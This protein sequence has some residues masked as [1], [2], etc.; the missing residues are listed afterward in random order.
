MAKIEL[1]VCKNGDDTFLVWRIEKPI[2]GCRGFAVYRRR[3]GK[4]EILPSYAGFANEDW[5][6]G[7]LKPSTVWPVQKF[8]WTD[9]TVMTGDEVSYRVVP[10]A[11]PDRNHLQPVEDQASDWSSPA[12]LDPWVTQQIGCYFNRGI[13]ATQW[14]QRM[15]GASLSVRQRA[16]KL[17]QVVED[18]KNPTARNALAGELRDGLLDLLKKARSQKLQV[19]AALFELTDDELIGALAALGEK[20]FVVL[21]DGAVS[22][23]K[24]S[25]N[26]VPAA[27]STTDEN[28]VARKT[29]EKAK[30]EVHSRMTK[31]KFLAHNK[32]LVVCDEKGNPHLTW[33]G[34]TN[35][36]PSGLC[37][38]ANN[39]LLIDDG[40]LATHFQ[41]Q[42]K[43]LALAGD[44]SPPS[45]ASVNSE[46]VRAKLGKRPVTVWFTRTNAEVDLDDAK[47]RIAAARDGALFLMF[48]TGAKGS[49][50]E[51]IMNRRTDPGFYIHGVIS[52]PPAEGGKKD[53]S[54]G[55]KRKL[56]AEEAVA[57]RVAFVH[58]GERIKYAPDLLLPFAQRESEHWFAEFV[59]KNGA[60][61]IVHSKIIVLDPFG[62]NPIVMTGSHNMGKTASSK[63]DENLVIIEGDA[64]LAAA[65]AVNIM[66]I[67][68][69][70]RWRYRVAAKSKWKGLDDNDTWQKEYMGNAAPELQFWL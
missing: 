42:I 1:R 44:A 31:G 37:T 65:Y 16:A 10:M 9:Y 66:S 15:L 47:A 32:I 54:S 17:D 58:H 25:D 7:D 62:K 20:A 13:V 21:A 24:K 6:R 50:L 35:W 27:K 49:L 8:M 51:A 18:L 41:E 55:T 11:G 56:T 4:E 40:P 69:N 38:Q 68:D 33:T 28:A 57:N 23:P 61:A 59:K 12:K 26:D 5:K 46:P 29:L 70:Y 48:Q 2:P 63:N 36:T 53:G 22:A 64:D 34:S 30:V 60:H 67:Y 45:L 43:K 39:G 3:N 14:V 19:Y 52:S